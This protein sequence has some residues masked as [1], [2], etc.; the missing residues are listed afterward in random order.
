MADPPGRV[1]DASTPVQTTHNPFHHIFDKVSHAA[2]SAASTL[3]GKAHEVANDPNV[4]KQIQN[5]AHVGG[6]IV[7]GVG[8]GLQR[9]GQETL[10]A[11][12]RGDVVGVATHVAPLM[13]G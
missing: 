1:T 8:T 2:T 7:Q 9:E 13:I 11:A 5:G 3:S 4:K 10:A 12:K 6:N